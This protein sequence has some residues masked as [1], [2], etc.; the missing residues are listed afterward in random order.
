MLT[1]RT[2]LTGGVF[3]GT[4][5]ASPASTKAAEAQ[6]SR[7]DKTD[8]ALVKAVEEIRDQLRADAGG[9]NAE[10]A[11]IRSLQREFVKGR[12]KFPDF[13]EVGIDVWDSLTNWYVRTRQ[14]QP[15]VGRTG[16][17]RYAMP[18]FQTNVILRHDVSNNYI[19]QPYDAK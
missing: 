13:I 3:T 7:G 9:S 2:L 5:A 16:D 1:R 6:S 4:L 15:Q 14:G 8:E 18:V 12:G 17:G 19:G 10:L 11:A